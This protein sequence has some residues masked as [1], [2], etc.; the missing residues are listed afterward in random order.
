MPPKRKGKKPIKSDVRPSRRVAPP[1]RRFARD[2]GNAHPRASR[3][4]FSHTQRRIESPARTIDRSIAVAP[5]PPPRDWF[6][7][8]RVRV[9][10]AVP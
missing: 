3:A 6:P 2:R 10:N 8:D 5:P 7:Y 1:R 4:A 9:V